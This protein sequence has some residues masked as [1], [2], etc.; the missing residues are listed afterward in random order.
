MKHFNHKTIS[1][2]NYQALPL[3]GVLAHWSAFHSS[4][5]NSDS[6][7]FDEEIS[8]GV[9]VPP[10]HQCCRWTGGENMPKL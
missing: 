2:N 4:L 5:Q 9:F 3:A 6:S 7:N 1:Y 8:F 10:V